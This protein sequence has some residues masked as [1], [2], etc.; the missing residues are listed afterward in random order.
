MRR[1][2]LVQRHEQTYSELGLNV[3]RF[4]YGSSKLA[5]CHWPAQHLSRESRSELECRKAMFMSKRKPCSLMRW[6]PVP[7]TGRS[8][9]QGVPGT[10]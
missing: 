10:D 8:G 3:A 9:H 7:G 4:S 6:Q 5:Y 1:C 2:V